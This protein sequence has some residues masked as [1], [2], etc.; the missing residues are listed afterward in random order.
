ML[1]TP[2]SEATTLRILVLCYEL[3]P[4]GGGGGRIALDV[5]RGLL[6]RGHSVRVLTSHV[7]GLAR[8]ETIQGVSV[9]RAFAARRRA[10]RCSVPEMAGYVAMHIAPALHEIGTFKPDVVHVHFAVP[11]GAVAWAATRLRS[12]PYLLTAHLGDVP[13]GAPEQTE[14]LFRFVKPFTVPIW[15]SAAGVTAVSDFVARCAG[16]AYG[17]MPVVIPN[18]IP[19]PAIIGPKTYAIDRPIRLVWAGRM[20]PQKNLLNGLAG[21]AGVS[22]RRWCLDVVGDGPQRGE[23]EAMC[24]EIGLDGHVRFYGWVDTPQV[25]QI[26][27]NADIMFLPSHSEGLSLASLEGLRAGLAFLA[28]RIP[29]V[30][31]VIEDN[32]NGTLCD[33]ARPSEFGAGLKRL[34][35]DPAILMRMQAESR[36]RAN[37]FDSERMIGGYERELRRIA[38]SYRK[39]SYAEQ[40]V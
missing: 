30:E 20:Q 24:K 5:A 26:M 23:I 4:V 21:L 31:G 19:M 1:Q 25:F 2:K 27:E 13:G 22:G 35:D 12:V 8:E 28:S 11:T 16:N 38:L 18:G 3:P 7:A 36:Q 15:R 37:A 29:G 9:R 6:G 14:R 33:P 39:P 10:D 17:M 32:V 34:I 40:A